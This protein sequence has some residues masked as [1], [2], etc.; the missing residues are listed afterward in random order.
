[1]AVQQPQTPYVQIIR[2]TFAL[3][4]ALAVF[5]GCE[6][7]R[8][9]AE[10]T[11]SQEEAVLRSTAGSAA[12][13]TVT[14][15]GPWTLT[16][17]GSGFGISPTAGGRGETTVTVTASD[18]NPGRSRVK[19]GTVTLT[20]NAGGAQCSVTVSQSPATATQTMLLYMP[21]RDLLKFYKQNID[22]VLKA[23]DANVPGDGRVLVCYQPNA[24]SQA[25]MYEAYFNAEKQ[26][27]A[28]AL[29]KTYDDFAAAD[30]A[31]V[32]RMLA[33]VEAFAP[34][35]H[36]GIIVGCHGKAWVP[37]NQGALSY[38]ARMSKELEDLW[39][40]APGALTTRSFGDTGR[41][42]DI[43]DFAAA[44]KA[45]N[46]RT[47][48][49]LFDACFMA[50]I[51]TLY[52][53]C[54][55]TDYV[56]AAPCEIMGEGFPYER[57]MPWFFTDG[58]KGRDLTKVC[59]A[60]W[61]FYMNDATTRSGCISLAVMS[62]M[63]E[64]KEVMRR[65]NAAPKKSY[66]EEL[67]SYEG[68]SSHIFYDLGHWVELACGD[69]KLKEDFK[70]QLDKAFP[71]AARLSTPGFY[72]AYNGRMNPVAYYSGVSFSEPSDKYV[73]ENKQTSWYRDTH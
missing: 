46:Y 17:T 48:Y 36:Y 55:C 58:G 73:E 31:C 69:A 11:S 28:F 29:L 22:G 21:G 50:N 43:T 47:D 26:A 30:P 8:E 10:I 52:D 3:L 39:T 40:P 12:A 63:E 37:A 60:F 51:E 42:I 62:E 57:A 38:S 19:L 70:A 15:T 7:E 16:T 2:R 71:K 67:Q 68:M 45:Q 72:S 66:A 1:M 65:I 13:F 41:S 9:P 27:A 34:A 44:V 32:Q 6:K 49:L 20:L 61:N 5:A 54:E 59:E 24:H 35:Q 56:I 53:L 18:G 14:A 64:M 4:L 23:V 33:D 25:E